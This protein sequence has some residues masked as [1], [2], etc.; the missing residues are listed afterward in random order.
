MPLDANVHVRKGDVVSLHAKVTHDPAVSGGGW[1]FLTL[2][3]GTLVSM[4]RKHIVE[5]VG[6]TFDKGDVVRV[7]AAGI[8]QHGEV[9][10]VHGDYLMVK[11]EGASVPVV[12]SAKTAELVQAPADAELAPEPQPVPGVYDPK[13]PISEDPP[14]SDPDS[15]ME[16]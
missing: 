13:P 10:A 8:T 12:A 14:A 5:I 6:R 9:L 11:V 4:D 1:I 7:F 2:D 16:F 3:D 15:A